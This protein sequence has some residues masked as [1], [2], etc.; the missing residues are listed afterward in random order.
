ME[1]RK[2]ILLRSI[3]FVKPYDE[4]SG[5][6]A[7]KKAGWHDLHAKN[8]WFAGQ[9]ITWILSEL[10]H[11]IHRYDFETGPMAIRTTLTNHTRK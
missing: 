5:L 10:L 3:L 6:G 1:R 8:P 4:P 9:A 7:G 11:L 2:W